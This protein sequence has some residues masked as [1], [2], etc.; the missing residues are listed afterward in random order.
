MLAHHGRHI[1]RQLAWREML[2]ASAPAS[3]IPVHVQRVIQATKGQNTRS[4]VDASFV[5]SIIPHIWANSYAT[6]IG[7]PKAHTGKRQAKKKSTSKAT[8]KPKSK[9]EE[10]LTAEQKEAQETRKQR[11]EIREL[12]AVALTEPKKLGNS[13]WM[14]YLA[15]YLKGAELKGGSPETM[16]ATFR[17]ASQKFKIMSPEELE[18]YTRQAESNKATNV[19]AYEAWVKSYTPLQI[20]QANLARKKLAKLT[21]K[22][23]HQITL[24][25]I[26]DDRQVKA[27]RNSFSLYATERYGSSGAKDFT[28]VITQCAEE[29]KNLPDSQKEKYVKLADAGRDNYVKE[30]RS[31]YG[32]DPGIIKKSH[33]DPD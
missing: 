16:K 2:C 15:A 8:D 7:R 25:Q 31:V 17:E 24:K 20:R 1:F 33:Q 30:Y 32:E 18:R 11:T 9:T 28:S 19:S 14:I 22:R 5:R 21:E 4:N 26:H 10:T 3:M 13:T 6:S 23:R 29:W 12:K 27:P